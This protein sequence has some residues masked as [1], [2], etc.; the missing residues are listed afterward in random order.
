MPLLDVDQRLPPLRVSIVG[1][2]DLD[3]PKGLT[4]NYAILLFYR[5]HW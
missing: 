5:A 1:A 3:L 2:P 4:T